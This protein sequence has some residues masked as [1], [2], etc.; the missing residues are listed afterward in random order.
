MSTAG[1]IQLIVFIALIFALTPVLGSYMAK[2]TTITT[3]KITS[4]TLSLLSRRLAAFVR[5][6]ARGGNAIHRELTHT[7]RRCDIGCRDVADL[8]QARFPVPELR[9]D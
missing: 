4:D 3:T 8:F 5:M 1:W 2:N 7:I 9:P 6:A